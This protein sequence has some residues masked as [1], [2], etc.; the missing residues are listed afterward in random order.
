VISFDVQ[1]GI[2]GARAIVATH[3]DVE[4][5][6]RTELDGLAALR[7]ARLDHGASLPRRVARI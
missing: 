4:A 2:H 6:L 7:E 3:R 5:V 1:L